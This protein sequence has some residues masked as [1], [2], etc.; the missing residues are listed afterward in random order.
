MYSHNPTH[1]LE[2]F[3]FMSSSSHEI[4]LMWGMW[5][6]VT[7]HNKSKKA[8]ELSPRRDSGYSEIQKEWNGKDWKMKTEIRMKIISLDEMSRGPEARDMH[9]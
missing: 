4:C 9:Y 7:R 3:F 8:H 5:K 2:L 6:H 1:L